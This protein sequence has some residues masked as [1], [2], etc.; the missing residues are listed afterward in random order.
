MYTD[1]F[2]T[3]WESLNLEE[4]YQRGY[5]LGVNDSL[6]TPMPDEFDRILDQFD[7]GYDRRLIE[8]AYDEG[9]TQGLSL[10]KDAED[11]DTVWTALVEAD[12][13]TGFE[14]PR[15]TEIPDAV[16]KAKLLDPPENDLDRVKLPRFLTRRGD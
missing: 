16:T 8:L 13:I 3:G 7:K 15:D 5:A 9:R 2:D 6:G 11:R 14:D 12:P 4:A 10:Q 1:K